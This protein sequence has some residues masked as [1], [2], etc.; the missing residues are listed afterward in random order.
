MQSLKAKRLAILKWSSGNEEELELPYTGVQFSSVAQSCPTL[1]PHGLQHARPPC[2]SPTP[3]VHSNSHTLLIGMQ[4]GTMTWKT[5]WQLLTKLN[6][7]LLYD[8]AIVVLSESE[9]EV[10]SDSLRPRGL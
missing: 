2:P 8:P 5:I 6:I 4:N 10:V 3:R 1:Q 9:S 7:N